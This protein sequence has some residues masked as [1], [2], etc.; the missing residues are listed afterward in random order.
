MNGLNIYI[1]IKLI[2]QGRMPLQHPSYLRSFVIREN[3][4]SQ[5]RRKFNNLILAAKLVF[6]KNTKGIER[7]IGCERWAGNRKRRRNPALK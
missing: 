1:Q 5:K 4:S 2:E 3:V 7:Q 6:R